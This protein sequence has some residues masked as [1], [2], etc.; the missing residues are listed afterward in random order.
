MGGLLVGE[1]AGDR[2]DRYVLP[3]D[4]PTP[5]DAEGFLDVSARPGSRDNRPQ[6]LAELTGFPSV[7]AL[8]A[9]GGAGKTFVMTR[10]SGC[11]PSAATVRLRTL[12]SPEMRA[13]IRGKIALGGPVYL[14]AL[15]DAANYERALFQVLEQELTTAAARSIPWRLACRPAAW[16]A[17][18]AVALKNAFPDFRQLK[19]LPLTRQAAEDFLAG[20]GISPGPFLDA[21][22]R[23]RLGRLSASPQRLRAV[24][25]EWSRTGELPE[26]HVEAISSEIGRF[27]AELDRG[28]PQPPVPADRRR[29]LAGR[30][31]AIAIFSGT[32]RF[33]RAA[34]AVDGV[35]G[36]S[37]LPSDP[38]PDVPGAPVAPTDYDAVL[39][40]DLFTAAPDA[41]VEF[42]HQQYAEFLAAEYLVGRQATRQQLRSLL[43]VQED[44][45][46]PGP[47]VSVAV[48]LAALQPD[49]AADLIA[50][51]ALAFAQAGIELPSH[52]LRAAVVDGLLSAAASGDIEPLPGL[53]LTS[54]AY[55]GLE[56][57]LAGH[58][59]SNR[60]RPDPAWWIAR[61]A[62]AGTCRALVPALL[63]LSLS[64]Q[65]PDWVRREAVTALAA[66]GD[67]QDL[68]QL[69]PLLALDRDQDPDGDE[70]PEGQLLSA[71]IGVLY[72]RLLSTAGLLAALG[73]QQN[74]SLRGHYY[75]LGRVGGDIPR[76]DVPQLLDW[77]A[78]HIP[79]IVGERYGSPLS[80]LTARGWE[81][82]AAEDART[83]LAR[84]L[85]SLA[86]DQAG[87][88]WISRAT[89]P[90][91]PTETARRRQLAA[92]TAAE[93][94]ITGRWHALID[95]R[96]IGPDDLDWL[97]TT[98]PGLPAPAQHALTACIP[99]LVVHPTAHQADVIL[100]LPQTHPAYEATQW[101]RN[102]VKTSSPGAARQREIRERDARHA[103]S[104]AAGREERATRLAEALDGAKADP[105]AWWQVASW[106]C[107]TDRSPAD[108][109]LFTA[110]LTTRPG[111]ALLDTQDQYLVFDLGVEY[112][113]VH[114]VQP[115]LWAGRKEITCGTAL[116]DWSGVYLLTTLARHDPDRVRALEPALWRKWA[117][118]IVGAWTSHQDEERQLRC[119]LTDLAPP[120]ALQYITSAALDYLDALNKH[121]GEF[122]HFI[123]RHLCPGLASRLA[124]RLAAGRYGS[125]LAVSL[126]NLLIAH[127]P[128]AALPACQRL[129]ATPE[130]ELASAA[131][132]GLAG[133]D[134]AAMVDELDAGTVVPAEL[135]EIM[136]HLAVTALSETHLA[137]LARVVLRCFPY[138]QY[139]SLRPDTNPPEGQYQ[140]RLFRNV[141]MGRLTEQGQVPVLEELA[142]QSQNEADRDTIRWHLRRAREHAADLTLARP[143]PP[144]LLRLLS[145]G[146]A[147][148]IRRATDLTEVIV[149]QLE[150]LQHELTYQGASREIWDFH[151]G[152]ATHNNEN[153]ITDWLR[154]KLRTRLTTATTIDREVQ[155]EPK[156]R[157]IGTRIDLTV[158]TPA[159]TYPATA[160]RVIAEAKLVTDGKLMTAMQDQLVNRYLIPAELQCGIYLVYWIDPGQRPTRTTICT[161]PGELLRQ[162]NGQAASAGPDFRI[163][164]FLLDISHK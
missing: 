123:Y 92:A 114:Q 133:L 82:A 112:L 55:P 146:D 152:R 153:E 37:G 41:S 93:I 142:S 134:P 36:V 21:L 28:R 49:L 154:R 120:D 102:P 17:G 140:V 33:G 103:E 69:R 51:N 2:L 35:L 43:G 38:E 136:P 9:A 88:I 107:A 1:F 109:E 111:W 76:D 20:E 97:V 8:L 52:D 75:L 31:G 46:V 145:R 24:A 117:T 11:E 159:V 129:R 98:L 62:V 105:A 23:A 127:A 113:A 63:Q 39:G 119:D 156:R 19:L 16:H 151:D 13:E 160:P 54:L 163:Q 77:A 95:L 83:A 7:F 18:L 71:V 90:W 132:Q 40:T 130:Q 5:V 125:D 14:D 162:L 3:V 118:A 158:T 96:L 45:L 15:E 121:G 87:E 91:T 86:D 99:G 74:S 155:V 59:A 124:D 48:W 30:L 115:E 84:L 78:A 25:V 80:V 70:D 126:L 143:S 6:H 29:R 44:G 144:A 81:E 161:D 138:S 116:P 56:A 53:D 128:Q 137:V 58:L 148:L 42:Q 104:L 34:E 61:L 94:G 64:A 10:L 67:E 4:Q 149:T 79:D 12:T 22:V 135:V 57:Q 27:L 72:P 157:G 50:Y 100:G 89:L 122:P 32:A 164:P 150:Q 131:R 47:M 108:V 101:L 68:V 139:P 73:P 106:L 65:R 110:D 26:S 60:G 147:R 85:A 66:L 141:V